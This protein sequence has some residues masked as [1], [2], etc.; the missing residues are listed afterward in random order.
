MSNKIALV[1]LIVGVLIRLS[2]FNLTSVREWLENRVEINTPLTSWNRVLEGIYLKTIIK[3]SPYEGDLF[4]EIPIMLKFYTLF[5]QIFKS[6]VLQN[7][8][9]IL[10]DTLNGL[11]VYKISEKIFLFIGQIEI[12]DLH[13]GKY[14]KLFKATTNNKKTIDD[15]KTKSSRFLI[16]SFNNTYLSYLILIIYYLNPYLIASCV[17]K[18]TVVVNNL[19]TCLWLYFLLSDRIRTSLLFLALQSHITVYQVMLIVP[20]IIYAYKSHC[21]A[22]ITSK[23]EKKKQ[24]FNK[25]HYFLITEYAFFFLIF[26][27]I[28]FGLNLYLENFN[29]RFVKS[30]YLFILQV[31]DL[32]PNLGIFWYF[33][34]EIFDHFRLFFTYVFQLNTFIYLI[35]LSIKLKDNP[36][37]LIFMQLGLI[38]VLKSYPT[39][40]ETGLYL[41]LL[42]IFTYLFR[43][44]RNFLIYSTMLLIST[45]LA[46]IMWHIWINSGSGNANFYF[47]ITLVYSVGHIFLLIDILYAYLKREYIKLNG[48]SIPKCEDG[49]DAMLAVE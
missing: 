7:L 46:P 31:P 39:V 22:E 5:T 48:P 24:N 25:S 21:L 34:I 35:P 10:L 44:M 20:S 38:S 3:I 18:S 17:C 28:I 26:L 37:M 4:H 1:A 12:T 11:L 42:P 6:V 13:L 33:F 36:I 9:F 2:L 16:S 40:G 14:E 30:T 41:T 45:I 47:A 8:I 27:A 43:F 19:I 29:L 32:Q 23:A 49:S 15:E